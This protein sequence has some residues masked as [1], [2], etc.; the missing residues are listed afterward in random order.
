[1]DQSEM[2]KRKNGNL[3]KCREFQDDNAHAV[4]N[5]LVSFFNIKTTKKNEVE[6][7]RFLQRRQSFVANFASGIYIT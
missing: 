1:M 3:K 6:G 4:E 7:L 5:G 2:P